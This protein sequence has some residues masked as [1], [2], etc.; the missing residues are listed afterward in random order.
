MGDL[1]P[2]RANRARKNGETRMIPTISAMSPGTSQITPPPF[3]DAPESGEEDEPEDQRDHTGNER[4]V[5]LAWR[6]GTPGQG[7]D[8][9]H[10][11]DG[12]GGV[13]GGE[14]RRDD[15]EH[16]GRH[17]HV[18][19]QGERAD[20]V[21]R[22]LLVVRPVGQPEH[23]AQR[24]AHDGPHDPDDDAVG[25]QDEPDVAVGRPHGLEHAEG[26]HAALRQHG[27]ATDRHQ[28]DQE[29]AHRRQR[30]HDGRRVD[31]VGVVRARRGDVGGQV[32]GFR[33][34]RR[35]RGRSPASGAS[36]GPA[37]RARTRR[38][39]S[40]G[41]ARCRRPS[42]RPGTTCRRSCRL[43]SD[44]K[45]GV[46]AIS[47]GPGRVV[48]GEQLQHRPAV[49]AV[50]ILGPQLIGLRRAGD[51]EGLV[52]DD[53]HRAEGCSS[54]AI[55]ASTYGR[56]VRRRLVRGRQV[57][58]G[59]VVGRA[60]PGVGRR[61]RVDRHGRADDDGRH[62]HDDEEQDQELLA[63]FALE[64]APGPTEHG[65]AGR[66]A[67]V[68]RRGAD[69]VA[70]RSRTPTLTSSG[71]RRGTRRGSRAAA[72]GRRRGRRAG[73]PRGRPTRRAARR[74]S[75]RRRP[76]RGGRPRGSAA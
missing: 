41:S 27:E 28:G 5:D 74:G 11:G 20:D 12:A 4:A 67:A 73:R 36:P 61:R 25:L 55:C 66:D 26:A 58:G 44:A 10:A 63:P 59:E 19:R 13:A 43:S 8:D 53:L 39:G 65:P 31:D 23:Q 18:P 22:A 40:G 57:E 64:E 51:V 16:H 68:A 72:S 15:G 76:G 56:R 14:E 9:R 7:A 60:E 50:R 54:T 48:P 32:L 70:G 6:R 45:P 34:A 30:Q 29:H 24:E 35:R 37:G 1:P 17:D 46:S 49:G 38:A 33:R 2:T 47:F 75:P 52:G 62:R 69:S 71:G 42:C 21:V 3:P